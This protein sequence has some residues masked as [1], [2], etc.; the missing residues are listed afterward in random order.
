MTKPCCIEGCA[1]IGARRR[2]CRTH[3]ER[4]LVHGDPTKTL[5]PRRSSGDGKGYISMRRKGT[6]A[7]AAHILIAEK[8]LGRPLPKGAEVH[9]VN[10]D[11]SDNTPTNLVICPSKKYHQLLHVR[12]EALKESGN[13]NARKCCYCLQY[14]IPTPSRNASCLGDHAPVWRTPARDLRRHAQD[15]LRPARM[16]RRQRIP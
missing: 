7:S 5:L 3:Y 1:G 15:S 6:A 11:K 2:M 13:A 14:D 4:W 16:V 10:Y 8:A 12:T 9:H